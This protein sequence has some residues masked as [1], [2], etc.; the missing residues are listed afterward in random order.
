MGKYG[1]ESSGVVQFGC[2]SK[3]EVERRG[4]TLV[5]TNWEMDETTGQL[6]KTTYLT[7]L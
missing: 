3:Q 4:E 6:V 2:P 1:V 7:E 5:V